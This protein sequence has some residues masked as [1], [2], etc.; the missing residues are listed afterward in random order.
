M[1]LDIRKWFFPLSI[2][3]RGKQTSVVKNNVEGTIYNDAI[4][5]AKLFPE[6]MKSE[7]TRVNFGLFTEVTTNGGTDQA[8]ALQLDNKQ[9][10]IV[11]PA[12]N[13]E[14]AKL[15]KHLSKTIMTIHNVSSANTLELFS[16]ENDKIN[17][18][19]NA[20]IT[21]NRNETAV[22]LAISD[23]NWVVLSNN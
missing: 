6:V 8:T 3:N 9:Y 5:L 20:S 23:N 1:A 13:G 18:V 22:L 15:P 12:N 16:F 19:V 21:I 4:P 17:G 11:D 14:T 10:Q 2:G 7:Y